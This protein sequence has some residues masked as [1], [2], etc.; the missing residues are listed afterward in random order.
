MGTRKGLSTQPICT[1]SRQVLGAISRPPSECCS[2]G[3]RLENC[4]LYPFV[5]R[6]KRLPLRPRIIRD[7]IV[8]QSAGGVRSVLEDLVSRIAGIGGKAG[9][10]FIAI[11][12]HPSPGWEHVHVA[13]DCL[14]SGSYCK[15]SWLSTFRRG[16]D[17]RGPLPYITSKAKG[18]LRPIYSSTIVTGESRYIENLL[19]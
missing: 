12:G 5:E 15:C 10:S 6:I 4:S 13:H 8:C 14:Y 11:A 2:P 16:R 3:L 7:V 17:Y 18:D 19:Q 9:S 1:N